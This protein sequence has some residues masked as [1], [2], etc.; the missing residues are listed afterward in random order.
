MTATSLEIQQQGKKTLLM[1]KG[2]ARCEIKQ[3]KLNVIVKTKFAGVCCTTL[4]TFLY[5]KISQNAGEK[6]PCTKF[7]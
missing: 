1:D 3:T 6:S 2:M 7:S 5:I 4:S